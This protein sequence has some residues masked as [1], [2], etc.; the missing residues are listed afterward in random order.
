MGEQVR[1]KIIRPNFG[2][3]DPNIKGNRFAYYLFSFLTLVIFTIFTIYLI[4]SI[5]I[6]LQQEF[7]SLFINLTIFF[8]EIML[9]YYAVLLLWHFSKGF[10]KIKH[11]LTPLIDQREM[12]KEQ[13][14]F[15]SI[16]LPLYR[17]PVNIVKQTL[18]AAQDLDYPNFEVVLGKL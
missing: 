18:L 15:I 17:E 16:L 10:S 12:S 8:V 13:F 9:G 1:S 7:I 4:L 3:Y 5:G 11:P 2:I 6:I 14:P